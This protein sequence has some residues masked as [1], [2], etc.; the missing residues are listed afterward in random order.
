[1]LN[2]TS[3]CRNSVLILILGS[4]L[5]ACASSPITESPDP[6][7]SWNE[8]SSKKGIMEFVSAVTDSD[9]DHYVMPAE[10]IAVFDNDGT[11]W[12]EKPVY[13][14]LLFIFDRIRAMAPDHPEWQTTP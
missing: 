3:H 11:L 14:Q 6:L 8:G 5:G 10:R 9:S 12:A 13:F 7:P 4:I 2:I 1:M